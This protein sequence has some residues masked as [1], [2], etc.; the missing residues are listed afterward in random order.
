VPL[1]VRRPSRW[2]TGLIAIAAL[3]LTVRLGYVFIYQYHV[4]IGGDSYYYHYG[5]NLLADGKGFIQPY[6]YYQRHWTVQAAEHPPLYIVI[7][8]LESLCGGRSYTDHQVL[9][10]LIG[11]ITIFVIGYTAKEL[12]GKGAGIFAA[13]IVAIY[14][15]F[16]FNDGGILSEGTA[17]LTTAVTVLVAYRFWKHRSVKGAIW[18][19]VWIALATLS[20]A[21]AILLPVLLMVPLV[22]F[23]KG[24][25][26]KRRIML[27]LVS[28][29]ASIVV[30]GPWVGYNLSRFDKPVTVSSGFDV[31]LA[32]ANCDLTYF[33]EFRGYWSAPCV[34]YIPR[35]YRDLSDQAT[36]YRK[37]ALDYIKAH[38]KDLPMLILA[39]EGRTWDWYRPLQNPQLDSTLETKPIN[40]GYFGLGILY[41]LEFFSLIGF[42][43]MR[44]RKIPVTPLI[45]LI[46][47]V[48]ISTAIT[49]GQ[50][51]YRASAEVALVLMATAGFAGLWELF[52]GRHPPREPSVDVTKSPGT[53][54]VIS[55]TDP[56]EQWAHPR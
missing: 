25:A 20:R 23:M 15:Y 47:N 40:W 52:T 35:V 49:F 33:G 19:G 11:T 54:G 16:W 53:P 36:V 21:E 31:T 55:D 46:I 18:L 2:W 39:R 28:G 41:V 6:D 48:T 26:W 4:H 1:R 8:A 45:A 10:C 24:L 56:A 51:R 7:L 9:S 38:E 12:F 17:Q 22:L 37:Q 14:P 34:I 13:V 44:R 43:V 27:I 30:L 50:S 32:S 5:A 42:Y 3:G 29:F